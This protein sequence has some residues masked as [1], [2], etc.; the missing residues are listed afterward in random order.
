MRFASTRSPA[1]AVRFDEAVLDGFPADGGLY[2]PVGDA[3]LRTL[4]LSLDAATPWPDVAALSASALFSGELDPEAA[5][6]AAG[7]LNGFPPA[8]I[9]L[10][11]DVSLVDLCGGPSHGFKD[12]GMGFLAALAGDLLSRRDGRA[13]VLL[14]TTG[15]TGAAAA[16][17]FAGSGRFDVVLLYPRGPVQGVLAERR[18]NA[19]G[20]VSA[21]AVDGDLAAC[22]ALVRSAYA[23]RP[24]A[25]RLGLVP[26]T[27]ANVGRLVPQVLYYM[28]AFAALKARTPG[29]FLV[30]IPGGNLGNLISGLYAWKW[31]LPV[32]GFVLADSDSGPPDGK[33][34]DYLLGGTAARGE[35]RFD[36]DDPENRER[37]AALASGAPEVLRS[38]VSS[39]PVTAEKAAAGARAAYRKAGVFLDPGAAAAYAAVREL[40]DA[41][42]LSGAVRVALPC[43]QHPARSA[44]AVEAACGV[45]PP[46]PEALGRMLRTFEP[47]LRIKAE[48]GALAAALASIR[49]GA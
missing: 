23:D 16:E 20:N 42:G 29:D 13:L 14:A 5:E 32:S 28:A 45:R 2:A 33:L 35:R 44:A 12:Y 7:A 4:S 31:G 27:S 22:K 48:P 26:A 18:R 39:V 40:I 8:T 3:D 43:L 15:D 41:E 38:M 9:D 46:V 34:V 19:G 11:G 24:L 1:M 36:E 37:I 30:A 25:A 47:D 6:R 21:V 10:D 17:A 49:A